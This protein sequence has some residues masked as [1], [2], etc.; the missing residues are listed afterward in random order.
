MT[1]IVTYYQRDS[2]YRQFGCVVVVS[3]VGGQHGWWMVELNV[4]GGGSGVDKPDW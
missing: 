1:T 2:Y 4:V 3:G